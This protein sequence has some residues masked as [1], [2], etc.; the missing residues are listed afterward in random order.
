[1]L[2][3]IFVIRHLRRPIYRV[4][5]AFMKPVQ[6]GCINTELCMVGRVETTFALS[7]IGQRGRV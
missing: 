6:I 2:Y 5:N 4:L 7:A 1:M 3:T